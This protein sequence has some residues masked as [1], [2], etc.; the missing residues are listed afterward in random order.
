MTVL[1]KEF[2]V[3]RRA[4]ILGISIS[5][6]CIAHCLFLPL[7]L[8]ALALLGLSIAPDPVIEQGLILLSVLIAGFSAAAGY[9]RH[10]RNAAPFAFFLAGSALVI[11]SQFLVKESLEP[12]VLPAGALLFVICHAV[13]RRLCKTCPAC[14]NRTLESD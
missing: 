6:L 9:Y 11:F 14:R 8:P 13:N 2:G 12:I 1:L 10:H 4:D 5:A 7:F 3:E